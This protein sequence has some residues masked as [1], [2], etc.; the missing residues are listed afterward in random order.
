MPDINETIFYGV[1]GLAGQN[2]FLDNF[3]IT[4]TSYTAMLI[5]FLVAII[6]VFWDKRK[7]FAQK[8]ENKRVYYVLLSVIITMILVYFVKNILKIPRP[9]EAL[10][11]VHQ[12]IPETKGVSFP[13]G[14]AAFVMSLVTSVYLIH[15]QYRKMF[16]VKVLFVV[17]FL[18][19][20]SR[21][22]VG[23]HY[24]IDVAVGAF[25]GT[26]ISFGFFKL[27]RKYLD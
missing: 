17:A 6:F 22:F 19:I 18:V 13:S 26:L 23:V 11:G 9:F 4:I 7:S 15:P 5:I 21:V 24:P 20:Y 10:R 1:N 8:L 12:L 25:M 27:F 3:F 14:H 16:F 2:A